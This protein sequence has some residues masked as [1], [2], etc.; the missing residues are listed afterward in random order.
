M[1]MPLENCLNPGEFGEEFYSKA[2]RAG[3]LIRLECVGSLRATE[4]TN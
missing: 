2:S 3:L 4:L 1:L